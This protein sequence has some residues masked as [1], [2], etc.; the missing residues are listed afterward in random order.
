MYIPLQGST[1]WDYFVG[2]MWQLNWLLHSSNNMLVR[3]YVCVATQTESLVFMSFASIIPN[4]LSQC[5]HM[6]MSTFCNL[7]CV[8]YVVVFFSCYLHCVVMFVCGLVLQISNDCDC[9]LL[10][11]SSTCLLVSQPM[12]NVEK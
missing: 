8:A 12:E 5:A 4:I 6:H 10:F 2:F 9:F 1:N 7:H 11:K 3:S